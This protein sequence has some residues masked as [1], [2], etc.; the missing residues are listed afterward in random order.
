[1]PPS[2]VDFGDWIEEARGLAK[3]QGPIPSSDRTILRRTLVELHDLFLRSPNS[4]QKSYRAMAD[5]RILARQKLFEDQLAHGRLSWSL[6]EDGPEE[7]AATLGSLIRAVDWTLGQ[8]RSQWPASSQQWL[9]EDLGWYVIPRDGPSRSR[10]LAQGQLYEKR[11][12]VFHR[13]VPRNIGGYLVEVVN[14]RTRHPSVGGAGDW[15]MGAC[16]FDELSLQPSFSEE[17]EEKRFVVVGVHCADAEGAVVSQ[18]ED[19]L[20]EGCIAVVWPELTVPPALREKIR[21]L[22]AGR[23]VADPRFPP[24]VVVTGSWHEDLEGGGIANRARIYDGYGIER[25]AYDK[26]APY[27]DCKWGR[28]AITPGERICVLATE[29]ALTGFAICLDFCD[30]ASNP[31]TNLDIDFMLVPSM[32][33]D[34]TMEGHQMT[35][36]AVEV[37]FGTRTFVVQFITETEFQDGRIGAVIPM[38]KKPAATAIKDM[39]QNA[40]WKAYPWPKNT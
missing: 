19:A 5:R 21:G 12:I 1:M 35:A 11:G 29:G 25:L 17:G 27:A 40:V 7:I 39:G 3:L 2:D 34:R 22:L 32:G 4:V 8:Y 6:P 16:L 20:N 33:N 36:A 10:S 31:F 9:V 14:T 24:S 23:D 15:R 30:M 13:L 38:P 37:K 28:E 18:V 26:I